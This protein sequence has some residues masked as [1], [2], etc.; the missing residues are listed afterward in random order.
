MVQTGEK[1]K[2]GRGDKEGSKKVNYRDVINGK[3]TNTRDPEVRIKD[4]G[5]T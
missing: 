1:D 3:F 5:R 4:G 2:D